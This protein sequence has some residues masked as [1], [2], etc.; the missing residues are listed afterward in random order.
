[1]EQESGDRI[2]LFVDAENLIIEAQKQGLPVNMR[3]LIDRVREDGILSVARAYADWTQPHTMAYTH[4]F[5]DAVIELTQL[6]TVFGKN[7]GDIQIVVDALEMALSQMAPERFVI[8]AGD[9]D[10]VPLIQRLRRYRKHVTGIGLRDSSSPQLQSI[11]DTFWFYEDLLPR[12]Q[13][14]APPEGGGNGNGAGRAESFAPRETLT[15]LGALRSTLPPAP[16]LATNGNGSGNAEDAE[17]SDLQ[18]ELRAAFELL[19]R[20]VGALDRNNQIAVASNVKPKMQQLDPTFDFGRF[21]FETFQL[22][23]DAAAR[24]GYVVPGG[25]FSGQRILRPGR[26]PTLPVPPELRFAGH[27]DGDADALRFYREALANKRVPLVQ[28]DQ[29]RRLIEHLWERLELDEDEEGPGFTLQEMTDILADGAGRSYF[30]LPRVAVEKLAY[31][32]II[33][34]AVRQTNPLEPELRQRRYHADGP[35]EEGLLRINTAYVRGI[36]IDYP[37]VVLMQ[38]PLALLLFG[39]DSGDALLLVDEIMGRLGVYVGS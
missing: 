1:M 36:R 39:S 27:F 23:I 20:A 14:G 12:T 31:T 9:R 15:S 3:L 22:F 8:V 16:A 4:S 29:R 24:Y 6:A 30:N 28:W 35:V 19:L 17:S 21:G 5:H 26:R 34:R 2:A 32:A 25:E 38:R 13:L 7:T 33:G 10:Y 18:P 11:C 37:D